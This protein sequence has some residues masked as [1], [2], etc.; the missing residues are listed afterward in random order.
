[1]K[2]TNVYKYS[3]E[4]SLDTAVNETSTMLLRTFSFIVRHKIMVAQ[5]E[6]KVIRLKLLQLQRQE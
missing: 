5:Q 4:R 3:S 6:A 1:M 2:A